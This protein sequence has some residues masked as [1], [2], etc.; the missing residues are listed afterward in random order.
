MSKTAVITGGSRGIGNAMSRKLGEMGYNVVINYVSD[1][2]KVISED[3][4]KDIEEKYGVGT[5]VVRA[6]VSKY[7][8]C[9]ALVKAA[10]DKFGE[11]IDV[12]VNNAGI[13]N[14]CNF[15][16]ITK[17]QYTAVINTNLMSL[18]H[19]C[20]LTLPHMVD[21]D[22]CIINTSSIG[23]LIGVE[24]QADYCAAK[25][26]VLGL[27][28]ALALE[29][30][31]RKVRVNAIAP[32]MIMSDMLKGVNQDELNAL[33]SGIPLGKIGDVSDISGCM[34]YIISAPYLTGQ[35]ISPNGGFV[36]P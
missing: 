26:G 4:A 28:R 27:T 20:H 32:G 10:I 17:E 3:L 2:S 30:A 11:K 7:E 31:G 14:N 8:D 36:M 33:A 12:L 21:H 23:G 19:M 22:S 16:D 1:S 34:E 9:E 13:T 25:S 35:T 29:Y 18:L 15:I 6:D 24:N 5:L